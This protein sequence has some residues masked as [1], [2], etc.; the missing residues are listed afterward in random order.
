MSGGFKY[1]AS[2]KLPQDSLYVRAAAI[3]RAANRCEAL[4]ELLL[5]RNDAIHEFL[6]TP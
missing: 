2:P 1:D 3:V 6:R 4:R 5:G